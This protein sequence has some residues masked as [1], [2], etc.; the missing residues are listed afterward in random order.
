ME[1]YNNFVIVSFSSKIIEKGVNDEKEKFNFNYSFAYSFKHDDQY[2]YTFAGWN[3]KEDGTGETVEFTDLVIT[4]AVTY[5]AQ[6]TSALRSYNISFAVDT[7]GF[8]TL[9]RYLIS[10]VYYGAVITVD[11]NT[12]TIGDTTITAGSDGSYTFTMPSENVTITAEFAKLSYDI[13]I[14]DSITNGTVT[15]S[16]TS[17]V[18]DEV[19]GNGKYSC[20]IPGSTVFVGSNTNVSGTDV[21]LSDLLKLVVEDFDV[22]DASTCTFYVGARLFATE[23]S[24][25]EDG[26]LF[27]STSATF[28]FTR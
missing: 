22:S 1:R 6:Y 19:V 9:D 13:S 10:D 21:Y 3:T 28:T 2:V 12:V 20:N 25:V 7:T 24:G 8:G 26:D 14:D 27:I 18:W 5:Y 17:S 11:G 15:V 23:E 16:E 4:G